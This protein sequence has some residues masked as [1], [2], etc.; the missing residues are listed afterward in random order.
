MIKKG[1]KSRDTQQRLYNIL[2]ANRNTPYC[3]TKQSRVV[4]MLSPMMYLVIWGYKEQLQR[5]VHVEQLRKLQLPECI[6]LRLLRA[7]ELAGKPLAKTT[8]G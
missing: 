7:S 6:H 3:V 4:K 8:M 5:V 1:N 2:L